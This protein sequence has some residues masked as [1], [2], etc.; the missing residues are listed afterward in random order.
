MFPALLNYDK[1]N[2]SWYE[3]EKI[4]GITASSIYVSDL[5]T[6]DLLKTIMDSIIN[7]QTN[8]PSEKEKDNINIYSNYQKIREKIFKKKIIHYIL[9]QRHI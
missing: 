6:P 7:I 3:V 4:K 8:L 5:M 2:F 1:T 9:D